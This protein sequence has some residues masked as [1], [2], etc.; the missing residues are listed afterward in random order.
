MIKN[1]N[2]NLPIRLVKMD[3][4]KNDLPIDHKQVSDFPAI[5]IFPKGDKHKPQH[6]DIPRESKAIYNWAKN[7]L[8]VFINEAADS[9]L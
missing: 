5:F 7:V 9:E 2:P 4:I 1:K 3:G 6:I 8:P